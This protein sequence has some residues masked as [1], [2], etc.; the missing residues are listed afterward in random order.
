MKKGFKKSLG[1]RIRD[2]RRNLGYS[3]EEIS[4]KLK[5]PRPS[6]S[7]IE[8]GQRDLTAQELSGLSQIFNLPLNQI[9][10]SRHVKSPS[11]A[12]HKGDIQITFFRHGEAVDDIFN[13][14]GGWADP[15]L[16]AKGVNKAFSVAQ[17]LKEKGKSFEIVY[18]SPLK[19]AKQKAEVVGRELGVDVK[20]L[21]YLKERN[22]Y[23]LLCGINKDV[24]QKRFPD[25]VKAYESG[26]YVLGSERYEDF[27]KRLKMIFDYIKRSG[28]R[29]V[30][31]VTHGK[32]ITAII[33][34]VLKM[35]PDSL[36]DG[37]L[38]EVGMDKEGIYYIQSEGITFN[39]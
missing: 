21:Q 33:K 37:C 26:K 34:E 22:T 28:H 13:Q 19:R 38:L 6:V 2:L 17:K 30:A 3:Q 24:A 5:I 14:Y 12:V 11:R 35:N 8:R 32:L 31:C 39:K 29:N 27:I 4:K 36:D 25:L 9:L 20:V 10:E 15:D 16:S 18:S 7:Q 1:K 23:G